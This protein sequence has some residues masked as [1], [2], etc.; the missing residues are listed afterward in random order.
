MALHREILGEVVETFRT[1]DPACGIVLIGSVAHG[2]EQP[3]SDLD[4][5]L[6]FSGSC[7]L[8]QHAYI[9]N[10]NR[11]QLKVKDELQG[12]RID[13]AWETYEG[14]EH[15]LHGDGPRGCWSF[16]RGEI[17]HDP[18]GRVA[19]GQL[20]ARQWFRNHPAVVAQLERDYADAKQLEAHRHSS[21]E[22]KS[23]QLERDSMP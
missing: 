23:Q 13:A 10:D 15:L 17:L 21:E 3:Q 22:G 1:L 5:N 7:E 14:L 18:S 2:N 8:P 20:I 12:I 6:F 16:S 4:L 9:G 11:W 19:S